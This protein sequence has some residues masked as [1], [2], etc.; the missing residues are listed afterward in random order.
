MSEPK[1]GDIFTTAHRGVPPKQGV[2]HL[3]SG[4]SIQIYPDNM[5]RSEIDGEGH[6]TNQNVAKGSSTRHTPPP[7]AR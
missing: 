7:D 3:D 5:R 1:G 6:W 4:K 2:L